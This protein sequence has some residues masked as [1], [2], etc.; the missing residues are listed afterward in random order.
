MH[1]NASKLVTMRVLAPEAK[2][3]IRMAVDAT[4][5]PDTEL[6]SYNELN[7]ALCV[8]KLRTAFA[9]GLAKVVAELYAPTDS[10]RALRLEFRIENLSHR[11][12][13]LGSGG[14]AT[15]RVELD[16]GL[17][18]LDGTGAVLLDVHQ[19]TPSPQPVTYN[20]FLDPIMGRMV[21]A[22][23]EDVARLLVDSKL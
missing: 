4:T 11:P 19:S 1:A 23:L 17:K 21:G 22:A 14:Y 12:T 13:S 20:G 6:C 8:S 10:A 2:A 15:S 7:R 5:L 3:S 16:W 18:V 9:K